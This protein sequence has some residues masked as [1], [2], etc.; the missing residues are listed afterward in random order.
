MG[1]MFSGMEG[2]GGIMPTDSLLGFNDGRLGVAAFGTGEEGR[3]GLGWG[4]CC[5]GRLSALFDAGIE[6][7][8]G[9]E[10][11]STGSGGRGGLPAGGGRV[12]DSSSSTESAFCR[13]SFS[14]R[15]PNS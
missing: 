4:S 11:S 14:S 5:K 13:R 2:T 1:G 8:G 10:S 7:L 3:D 9:G 12:L 15:D 6:P